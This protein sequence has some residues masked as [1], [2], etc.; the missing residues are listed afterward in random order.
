MAIQAGKIILFGSGESS[1]TGRAIHRKVFSSLGKKKHRVAILETPAGF[2]PNSEFVAIEI[3]RMFNES[4]QEFVEDVAIIP[5]RMKGTPMSPDNA[6]L[7]KPLEFSDVIFFGPGSPTYA[8]KQFRDS[9]AWKLIVNRWKEGA[10]LSLASAAILA[11][12]KRTLPVYE[13][14]KVGTEL[15]WEPGLNLLA[16]IG[17]PITVVSHWNN[18]EGG[19]NLDTSRCFMGKKRFEQLRKLLPD[20]E[21]FLGIDEHT[22]VIINPNYHSFSVE[23]KGVATVLV[24]E[25]EKQFFP[26]VSYDVESILTTTIIEAT[27]APVE[28]K[29]EKEEEKEL[30]LD[31]SALPSD[32][33][34]LIHQRDIA[35]NALDFATSDQ[36]RE[37]LKHQGYEVRDSVAG[38]H[39]FTRSLRNF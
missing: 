35:K 9:L 33:Q 11:V 29:I 10:I 28:K 8:L 39:I 16:E 15:F 13:I 12:G 1:P 25:K 4:L 3:A 32:I 7:L 38:Q 20:N 2:Q 21:V 27:E 18:Q 31:I 6:E 19:K 30:P 23:G 5:A 37:K 17:L 34:S 14:Y 22:A 36:L 24:G 26:G